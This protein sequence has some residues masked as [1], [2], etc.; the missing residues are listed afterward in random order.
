LPDEDDMKNRSWLLMALLLAAGAAHAQLYR[1][2]GPD[3]KVTYS[4]TPPPSSARGVETKNVTAGPSTNGLPYELAQAVKANPV[5][6]YTGTK[7]SPCEDGRTMLKTRGIP[8]TE[9]T[10][11]S[12]DDIAKLKQISGD[13]QLPVLTVGARKQKG[14]ESNAWD[15]MLNEAGYPQS[16]RLPPN[17]VNP[18]PEAAAPKAKSAAAPQ[19][20]AAAERPSSDALPDTPPPAGNA[21]PGF[22][23]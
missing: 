12:N 11:A 18:P 6:L 1:W 3:G 8:Y 14:F 2:V 4:D 20:P 21:P 16:N 22:R 17:Y 5:V 7:C 9:K 23:F 13:Q 15:A 19:A 10:V